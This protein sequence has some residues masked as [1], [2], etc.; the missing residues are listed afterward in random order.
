MGKVQRTSS[1]L[2]ATVAAITPVRDDHRAVAAQLAD[3]HAKFVTTGLLTIDRAHKILSGLVGIMFP[4]FCERPCQD[5][6][7]HTLANLHKELVSLIEAADT[8]NRLDAESIVSEYLTQLPAIADACLL[9]AEALLKGDP[10]AQS[11]E[12]VILAYPGFYAVTAYRLAHQLRA[13]DV[14]ILPR[15]MT[16]FAHQ[17]TGIDIHPGASIGKRFYIDHGTAVVIGET[18]IIGDNVKIYQGV[19][20]GGLK[21]D[22]DN[23]G[24]RHP[25]IENNVTIYAGATILG[26]NT[27]VGHDSLIG[28][29]VWLTRSVPPWSRVMFKGCDT[30]EIVPISERSKD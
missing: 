12:E 18:S 19:T 28:G 13:F 21:V 8:D 5:T 15:L 27:I 29:N 23:S 2:G 25:T 14:P 3:S 16:E 1:P 22:K 26:G 7:L 9:D 20:L 10:A 6:I 17:R 24:K 4:H 30:E 11:L